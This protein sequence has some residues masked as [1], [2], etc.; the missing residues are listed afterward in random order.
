MCSLPGNCYLQGVVIVRFDR[1]SN[2][3]LRAVFDVNKLLMSLTWRRSI[4]PPISQHVPSIKTDLLKLNRQSI[5]GR[6]RAS[7]CLREAVDCTIQ[8]IRVVA[9]IARWQDGTA[10]A[11]IRIDVVLQ[12]VGRVSLRRVG[13][14]C[15]QIV[16]LLIAVCTC[17]IQSL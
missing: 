13:V 12:I 2:P 9:D 6:R 17:N 1:W 7:I 8:R 3:Q 16:T 14:V 11:R 10:L 5:S 4:G 15:K